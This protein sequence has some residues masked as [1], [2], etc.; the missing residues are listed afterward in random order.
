[1][2]HGPARLLKRAIAAEVEAVFRDPA[3][4]EPPVVRRGTGLF[5]PG[6]VAARVHGDV[7]T[8][9]IGGITGLLLQ[10]LHPAVLAGVWD[11]SNFRADMHGRLRRTAGF[12]AVTTYGTRPEAE[13]A[14]ARVR[15]IHDRV[16]GTLPGGADYAAND[17]RLLAWVH[18]TEATSFVAAWKRYGEPGMS[19]RDEDRYFREMA[20]VGTALGA[21][22]VPESRA[23]ASAFIAAMRGELRADARTAEVAGLVLNQRSAK[24]AAEPLARL[25]MQAAIDLLPDWARR[26]HGLAN[27]RIGRPLLRAGAFGVASTLRWAFRPAS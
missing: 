13:A 6:A 12:I 25:T 24:V 19:A 8:M 23:A 14:V 4:R 10:M 3:G 16:A 2:A 1:M 11:H 22:P 27:P 18:A 7:T 15:G 5:E 21:A 26:M 17:P 20:A 9:M